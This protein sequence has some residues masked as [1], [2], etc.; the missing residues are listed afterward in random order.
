MSDNKSILAQRQ[1]GKIT[2]DTSKQ[3]K[4]ILAK[5]K[6]GMTKR[7]K[8]E[9]S[10]AECPFCHGKVK[11]TEEHAGSE[12]RNDVRKL[13]VKCTKCGF[14]GHFPVGYLRDLSFT[15]DQKSLNERIYTRTTNLWNRLKKINQK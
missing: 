1:Y 6:Y 8:Q 7:E 14:E 4:S 11:F 5:R 15:S 13:N 3:D 12:Y 2:I 9:E 10:L